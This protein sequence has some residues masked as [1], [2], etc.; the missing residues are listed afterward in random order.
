MLDLLGE[1]VV[2]SPLVKYKLDPLRRRD[3]TPTATGALLLKDLDLIVETARQAGVEVP[4]AKEVQAAYRAMAKPQ[5]AAE[6]F[7]SIVKRLAHRQARSRDLEVLVHAGDL[8]ARADRAALVDF[9]RAIRASCRADWPSELAVQKR[10]R[11]APGWSEAR[12]CGCLPTAGSAELRSPGRVDRIAEYLHDVTVLVTTT[13]ALRSLAE[14]QMLPARSSMIPSVPSR[15]GCAT[16]TLS[17]HSVL[18]VKVV[19]HPVRLFSSPRR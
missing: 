19:S 5:L 2:A 12:G 14:F 6:D 11:K 17:R 8:A 3:Y 18:A 4:L 15:Y 10:L 9:A 1:S 16:R 13:M 7:F